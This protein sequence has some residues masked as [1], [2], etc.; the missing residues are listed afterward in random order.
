VRI[1][2]NRWDDGFRF[3]L[4]SGTAEGFLRDLL[5]IELHVQDYRLVRELLIKRKRYR[6]DLVV[7][8]PKATTY[9]ETKQLHLKDGAR[10]VSNVWN[11]LRRHR[12]ARCLGVVYLLDER[13]SESKLCCPPFN[14]ANRKAPHG[15]G[16]ILAALQDKFSNVYPAK[17]QKARIRSFAGSGQ[18]DVYAFVVS[19]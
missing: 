14:N 18:L 1:V 5:A 2:P 17:E 12:Q 7:C 13:K 8:E 10:Y 19:L 15:V 3:V 16:E 11:D 9:I 6:V 4:E